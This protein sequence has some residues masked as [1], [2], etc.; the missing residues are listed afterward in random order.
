MTHP[1]LESRSRNRSDR[2]VAGVS[3]L[4]TVVFI[5][6]FVAAIVTAT[7]YLERAAQKRAAEGNSTYQQ[8]DLSEP[9]S[10]TP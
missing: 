8:Y 7:R 3:V 6:L 9:V 1:D 10:P 4:E 2:S 5:A